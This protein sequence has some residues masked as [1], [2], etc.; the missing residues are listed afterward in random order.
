MTRQSLARIAGALWCAAGAM[1]LA[2]GAGFW[3]I[4]RDGEHRSL[5]A[6]CLAVGVGVAIGAAKGRFVLRRS[7]AR[8]LARIGKLSEP[9]RPWQAFSPAFYLLIAAMIGLGVGV[10]VLAARGLPGGHATALGLYMAIG[11]A[12]I[13][14]STSY[15]RFSG[16]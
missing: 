10:R 3:R 13:V 9:T 6:L 7:A 14:S 2:R 8:N 15:W 12:L 16:R 11:A 4:A 1:L 5:A